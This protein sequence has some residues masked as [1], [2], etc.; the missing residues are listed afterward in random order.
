LLFFL[1]L[2]Q[3]FYF[4]L[5]LD[6]F[7]FF[8]HYFDIRL[9]CDILLQDCNCFLLLL[10][11]LF[12]ILCNIVYWCCFCACLCCNHKENTSPNQSPKF[13]TISVITFFKMFITHSIFFIN[14]INFLLI[15]INFIFFIRF[16]YY[17]VSKLNF[18][19]TFRAS[20]DLLE[21]C[22]M[23]CTCRCTIEH[24]TRS[25]HFYFIYFSVLYLCKNNNTL[26]KVDS[27][28]CL[29]LYTVAYVSVHI[30]KVIVQTSDYARFVIGNSFKLAIFY[31]YKICK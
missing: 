16:L 15:F 26:T 29:L 28:N 25:Y 8:K 10:Y 17:T 2:R 18:S 4:H 30:L 27:Y 11:V 5:H 7:L 14:F 19:S 23:A 24:T 31:S 12:L 13:I 21:K 22:V 1:L 20:V 6:N 3:V 9:L